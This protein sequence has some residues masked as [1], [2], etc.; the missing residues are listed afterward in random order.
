ML[1]KNAYST[2]VWLI[3]FYSATRSLL[4]KKQKF[5]F[6]KIFSFYQCPNPVSVVLEDFEIYDF[7]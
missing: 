3:D 4:G 7:L 2:T 5:D 6:F 1:L